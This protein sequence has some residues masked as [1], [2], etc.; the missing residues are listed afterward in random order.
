[1]KDPIVSLSGDTVED[2][3][4]NV[5]CTIKRTETVNDCGGAS[6]HWVRIDDED[7]GQVQP[8]RHF[9]GTAAIGFAVEAVVETHYAFDDDDI[10]T[11]ARTRKDELIDF[12]RD[13][14]D[15]QV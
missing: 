15:T 14:P 11:E 8:L 2:D 5:D 3:A 4:S 6:R 10:F 9:G 7:Y 13:Q 1:R 12:E